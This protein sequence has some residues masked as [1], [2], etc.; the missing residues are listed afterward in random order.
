MACTTRIYIQKVLRP[1]VHRKRSEFL[2]GCPIVLHDNS[3]PHISEGMTT[4][5]V[6]YKWETL[7][8]PPYSP[9]LSPCD[10]DLFP[11]LKE[12]MRG[13]RFKDL[14]ELK[15]AVANQ[16]RIYEHGCLATGIQKLPRRWSSVT[17]P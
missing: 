6:H 10:F 13:V 9:D 12:N 17:G 3:A 7:S 11:R 14:E 4:L 8:H 1:A 5:L 2:A 15:D 16:V